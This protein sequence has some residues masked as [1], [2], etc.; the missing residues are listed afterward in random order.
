LYQAITFFKK[1]L[2]YLGTFRGPP[3]EKRL[4]KT[5]EHS[6]KILGPSQ[7]ALRPSWCS[8]LVTGLGG[9]E[10]EVPFHNNIVD[11]FLVN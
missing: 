1:Y 10:A 2:S 5:I 3:V 8:N 4:F 7:K 11:I 9:T 6:S